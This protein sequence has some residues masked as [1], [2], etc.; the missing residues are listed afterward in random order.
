MRIDVRGAQYEEHPGNCFRVK[1]YSLL[2]AVLGMCLYFMTLFVL[3][4]IIEIYA[5]A[6]DFAP[7]FVKNLRSD[8]C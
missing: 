4:I 5:L 1:L 7:T 3:T 8:R 6:T 2:Y